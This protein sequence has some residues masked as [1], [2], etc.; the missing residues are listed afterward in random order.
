VTTATPV[1][2]AVGA[3]SST[4]RLGPG[5]AT[6]PRGL[7]RR[8]PVA[9]PAVGLLLSLLGLNFPWLGV[10]LETERHAVDLRVVAAGMPDSRLISYG[11]LAAI[12]LVVCATLLV[13]AKGRPT[14]AIAVCGA[15]MLMLPLLFV[16]QSAISDFQL[17]QHIN[18]Q[19]AEMRSITTQLGYSIPRSGPTSVLLYPIG[20]STRA[21]ATDLRPG[22]VMSVVGGALVFAF[23]L[24]ELFRALRTDRRLRWGSL[25]FGVV[26]A[27]LLGRGAFA[28]YIASSAEQ[29]SR[30]GEYSR[31]TQLFDYAQRLNPLLRF[32]ANF[33]LGLGQALGASGDS[34]SPLAL[35]A[36]SKALGTQNDTVDQLADLQQAATEAPSNLVIVQELISQAR[37][38]A[39]IDN[40]RG[41]MQAIVSQPYGDLPAA[42]YALGRIL[43]K[44]GDFD[45]AIDQF[46]RTIQ[47]TNDP[48]VR[49]SS[50]T[51]ISLGERAMGRDSDARTHLLTAIALDTEYNNS[52]ARSLAAGLYV[53]EPRKH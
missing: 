2:P 16:V 51:Y 25:A 34:N 50:Y 22:W 48:N 30:A 21:I 43:Y 3:G 42:H 28:N 10:A 35:Y 9:V 31:A 40:N 11:S 14:A 46:L 17:V 12:A 41:L 13:R 44:G 5:R 26:L 38:A 32:N 18:Q 1:R 7:L 4:P 47:L 24:V 19:N 37:K 23:G 45:H 33:E 52:L 15:I 53:S 6:E 39:L 36:Q 20:G 29:A 27:V 49:S 8:L